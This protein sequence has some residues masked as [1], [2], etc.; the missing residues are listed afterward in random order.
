MINLMYVVLMAMLAINVSTEVLNGFTVINGSMMQTSDAASDRNMTIYEDF[1]HQMELN[2]TK[3]QA[4]YSQAQ[5]IKILSDSLYLYTDELKNEIAR[6]TDGDNYDLQNIR[7]KEDLEAAAQVMLAP[8]TGK[9]EAL[10]LAINNYKNQLVSVTQSLGD[11]V[12]AQNIEHI[13][14][15]DVPNT[16]HSKT[17]KEYMFE[18]VPAIAAIT[19]LTK[20]QADIRHAEGEVLHSLLSNIDVKDIRVNKL[21]AFVIP[22]AQTIIRG[23]H[24]KA[25]IVM[26]AID[27]T[28]KPIVYIRG[29]ETKLNNG[30]YDIACNNT[31]NFTLNGYLETRT[32]TGETIKNPFSQD[33]T[34]IE[35]TATISADLM[36]VLYAGYDNPISISVPGVPLANISATV[37]EGA[38]TQKA[39]GKYIVKPHRVGQNI[40]ISV[41]ANSTGNKQQVA[42][43]TFKVRKLPDPSPYI[44]I[45][46]EKGNP[47]KFK[48]GKIEKSMLIATARL[49]AAVDDGLLNIPFRVKSFEMVIFDN[50]GN[51]IQITSDG[52]NFSRQQKETIKRIA[53]GK[54]IY[55]SRVIA[56][57]P[58]GI[59][60]KLPSAMEITIK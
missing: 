34:V 43:Y 27:S 19:Y 37:T 29:K 23:N 59:D 36:N 50:M 5:R 4:F 8:L 42:E 1:K 25:N 57:G 39:E 11:D 16:Q 6:E 56:T 2:P 44:S 21:S 26:A 41:F 22:N 53:K 3:T 55:L 40:T 7:N 45:K 58:D 46:D 17:W 51:A 15:T 54:R 20:L 48:G 12:K 9:G 14:S 52:N 10:W 30:I 32:K 47:D 49:D 33:Y 13:L 28:Q 35:P 24:F 38:I 31:G 18:S 60:R